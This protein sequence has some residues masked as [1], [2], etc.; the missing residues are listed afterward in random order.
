MTAHDDYVEML[1]SR[2]EAM[3]RRIEELESSC[4]CGGRP[5]GTHREESPSRADVPPQS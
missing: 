4:A 3:R 1:E 5:S 2:I